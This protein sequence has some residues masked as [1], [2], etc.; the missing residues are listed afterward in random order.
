M[1]AAVEPAPEQ[2]EAPGLVLQSDGATQDSRSNDITYQPHGVDNAIEASTYPMVEFTVG[3][4]SCGR[5]QSK[6][7]NIGPEG[8]VVSESPKFAHW[9]GYEHVRCALDQLPT[10]FS[11]ADTFMVLGVPKGSEPGDQMPLTTVARQAANGA[12][13]A[14]T[15]DNFRFAEDCIFLG[16]IDWKTHDCVPPMPVDTN[17]GFVLK[18]LHTVLKRQGI[19]DGLNT[20]AMLLR[21]SASAG[22]CFADGT[23]AK[24]SNGWH[25]LM[26]LKGKTPRELLEFFHKQ[27]VIDGHGHALV[28]SSGRVEVRTF[29]DAKVG[30]PNRVVFEAKPVLGEGLIR[31]AKEYRRPGKVLDLTGVDLTIDEEAYREACGALKHQPE[32]KR[33]VAEKKADYL[34]R[35]LAEGQAQGR[36]DGDV[37]AFVERAFGSKERIDLYPKDG[38]VFRFDDGRQATIADII[39]NPEAYHDCSLADPLDRELRPCKAKFYYNRSQPVP[40]LGSAPA[41]YVVNL[42]RSDQKLFLHAED[43]EERTP[44]ALAPCSADPALRGRVAALA[45]LPRLDYD[46]NR[47]EEAAAMGVTVNALDTAVAAARKCDEV[48]DDDTDGD[49][50]KPATLRNVLRAL[51]DPKVSG[52]QVAF[53]EFTSTEMWT[54]AGRTEWREWTEAQSIEMRMRLAAAGNLREIRKDTMNDALLVAAENNRIDTAQIWAEGLP[55]W[56]GTPRCE[57]FFVEHFNVEDSRYARAVGLYTWT[58]LAGRLWE[59]GV[60]ADM[61]PT[62]VGGQGLGKSSAVEAMAPTPET[63]VE[64]GLQESEDDLRRKMVGTLVGEINE[65]AGLNRKDIEALKAFL[66]RRVEKWVPKYRERARTYQRRL[67]FIA[68]TNQEQFL[69]D[70]TGNRRWLPLTVGRIDAA[71]IREA[72]DQLWAEAS[73][74][75]RREG[76]MFAEAERLATKWL[77]RHREENPYASLIADWLSTPQH[78]KTDGSLWADAPYLKPADIRRHALDSSPRDLHRLRVPVAEAMRELGWENKKARHERG[79]DPFWAWVRRTD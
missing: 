10:Y 45:Q 11:V 64:I 58:A 23:P 65:L 59:P 78:G 22:I 52:V 5:P 37:R 63:Y 33:L 68:T 2:K 30:D 55:A 44:E 71:G 42:I 24:D 53:D 66:A 73:I 4:A 50:R 48:E 62:L 76:V 61:V 35:K 16:D 21:P 72:L 13:I 56:D 60:K 54:P 41:Q 39:A 1:T 77:E 9:G 51:E 46:R 7:H 36:P 47:R 74:L 26:A 67:L 69:R 29:L 28:T 34:A 31:K 49:G 38:V 79:S 40:G 12:A 19:S 27:L 20:V 57:T 17:P 70:T 32:V 6:H 43:I 8:T 25:I 18:A 15:K 14:R 3:R 75:F